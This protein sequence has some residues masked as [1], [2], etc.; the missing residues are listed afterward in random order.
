MIPPLAG[1]IDEIDALNLPPVLSTL[2][3]ESKE[4]IVEISRIRWRMAA[5]D[6][7]FSISAIAPAGALIF[8]SWMK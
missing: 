1:S 3:D 2:A 7:N 5:Y 6:F 8:P 4:A